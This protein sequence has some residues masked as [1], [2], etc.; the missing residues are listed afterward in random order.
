MAV[1]VYEAVMK[2]L[3]RLQ[4]NDEHI[5]GLNIGKAANFCGTIIYEMRI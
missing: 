2:L 4:L 5:I 3:N 1:D